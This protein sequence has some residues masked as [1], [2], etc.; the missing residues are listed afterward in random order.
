MELFSKQIEAELSS[1]LTSPVSKKDVEDAISVLI[2]A[3]EN[4]TSKQIGILYIKII[5]LK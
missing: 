2:K 4:F 3:Q 1:V 5:K